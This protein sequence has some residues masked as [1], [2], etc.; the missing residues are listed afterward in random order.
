MKKI[1]FVIFTTI[2]LSFSAKAQETT[3]IVTAPSDNYSISVVGQQIYIKSND[4]QQE[5]PA[6]SPRRVTHDLDFDLLGPFYHGWSFLTGSSY[7]GDWA[8]K[9]DFLQPSH[10]FSFGMSFCKFSVSL[11][12][13]KTL[14]LSLGARWTFTRYTMKVPVVFED[15][16]SGKTQP[17]FYESTDKGY[18][19]QSYMGAP[20]SLYYEM[21]KFKVTAA[22]SA[23]GL[24]ASHSRLK[25]SDKK[26]EFTALNPFKSTAEIILSYGCLGAYAAYGITPMFRPGSGNDCHLMT[27]GFVFGI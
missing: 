22:V 4:K 24:L 2:A 17:V 25:N 5:T 13:R 19:Y 11:N 23:E 16:M 10:L 8:D 21:D 1:L 12:A 6:P 26:T 14:Y 15:D 27:F 18:M 20:L 9:G 7:Y 3:I